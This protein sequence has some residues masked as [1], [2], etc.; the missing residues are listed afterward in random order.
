MTAIVHVGNFILKT[1]YL[2]NRNSLGAI[3]RVDRET[4]CYWWEL[5]DG[6]SGKYWSRWKKAPYSD[7]LFDTF[8]E[9]KAD[10]VWR[11]SRHL[12]RARELT[13]CNSFVTTEGDD[14]PR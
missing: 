10:L 12:E 2:I 4:A 7:L 6:R 8:D 9:A 1:R 13:S 3:H 11:H 5:V 14:D